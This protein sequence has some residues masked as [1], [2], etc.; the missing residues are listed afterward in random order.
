[1]Y[2][3]NKMLSVL[4]LKKIN[5]EDDEG[6]GGAQLAGNRVSPDQQLQQF[7]LNPDKP[8][9][10]GANL[11]A[12]ASVLDPG[13]YVSAVRALRAH[14]AALASGDED[15]TQATTVQLVRIIGAINDYLSQARSA[16]KAVTGVDMA[17]FVRVAEASPHTRH[18]LGKLT[19]GNARLRKEAIPEA[20]E[21]ND[22]LKFA[23]SF[24][25]APTRDILKDRRRGA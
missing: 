15:A 7:D 17:K 20:T 12:L 11:E 24:A 16:S 22:R 1:M 6:S 25:K 13:L 5:E 23:A 3:F 4:G 18:L 10:L 19:S 8:N 14:N 2:E 21:I 9:A